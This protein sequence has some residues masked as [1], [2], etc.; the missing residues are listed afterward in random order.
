MK[1]LEIL[2]EDANIIIVNKPEGLLTTG[3]N[4][5]HTKTAVSI[6]EQ[7]LRK[8]GKYSAKYK[9]LCVH[10]LD[11][12]TSGVMMFAT[13]E[14][15]Q[16][17]IMDNWHKMVTSRKY[18]ALA[19]NNS[20]KPIAPQGVIEYPLAYNAYNIAYV[21]KDPDACKDL[22]RAKTNYKVICSGKR[23]TLFELELDTGRKNQIRAHLAFMGYPLAGDRN[24]R[25]RT[26]VLNRLGLHAVS[27]EFDH[28]FTHEHLKFEVNEPEEWKSFC[29]GEKKTQ[30]DK[31]SK[32]R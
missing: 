29:G 17:I 13:N 11:R 15:A 27:L 1:R 10:R 21:P 19:E 14:R 28:P 31:N 2:Y 24:Y 22:V 8:T 9:P 4:G 16:K 12:E 5:S 26:D 20:R 3:Y 6:L 23:F 30:F 32:S 7:I 25:A 18:R